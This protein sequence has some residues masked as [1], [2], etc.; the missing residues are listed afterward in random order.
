MKNQLQIWEQVSPNP[1][2]ANRFRLVEVYETVDGMRS[3]LTNQSFS[4]LAEANYFIN[5][6]RR[7]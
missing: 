3:R 6:G 5:E 1:A 7:N 4:S 2:A